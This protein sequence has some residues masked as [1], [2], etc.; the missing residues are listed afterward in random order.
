MPPN[1]VRITTPAE[2]SIA[3][4]LLSRLAI[5]GSMV[6]PAEIFRDGDGRPLADPYSPIA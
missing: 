3:D 5:I 6:V 4:A 2:P 1:A